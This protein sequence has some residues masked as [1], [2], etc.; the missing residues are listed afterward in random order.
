M[1]TPLYYQI[2]L[3]NKQTKKKKPRKNNLIALMVEELSWV[4]E[5]SVIEEIEKQVGEW[6]MEGRR[7]RT[8]GARD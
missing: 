8:K 2:Y 1:R 7:H 6:G 3:P 4:L 5:V